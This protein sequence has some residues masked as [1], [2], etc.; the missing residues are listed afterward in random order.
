MCFIGANLL[1]TALSLLSALWRLRVAPYGRLDGSVEGLPRIE[2]KRCRAFSSR[3]SCVRHATPRMSWLRSWL[4]SSTGEVGPWSDPQGFGA[5]LPTVDDGSVA[6][7]A[8]VSV[9]L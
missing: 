3:L 2:D 6:T 5:V 7:T 9:P 4:Q 8:G 1:A